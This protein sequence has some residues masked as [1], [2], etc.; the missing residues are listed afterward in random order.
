M[1]LSTRLPIVPDTDVATAAGLFLREVSASPMVHHCHRTFLFAE[2]IGE[3]VGL[4]ADKEAL[5]VSALFHD[6]GLDYAIDGDD[7]F[8]VRGGKAA[9][10]FLLARNAP[11]KFASSVR[12]AIELHTDLNSAND[13]RPEVAL[14]HMGAMVDVIGMRI[15]DIP[16]I[17]LQRILEEHPRRG[18]KVHLRTMLSAEAMRKPSSGIAAAMQNLK[19]GDLIEQSPFDD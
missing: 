1:M 14:L 13:D 5:Y 17:A 6:L 2:L 3:K 15:D 11:I 8:E 19:L 18:C 16:A 4:R 10:T 9:E 7:E 12:T